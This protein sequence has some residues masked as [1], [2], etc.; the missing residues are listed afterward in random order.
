[1]DDRASPIGVNRDCTPA[2]GLIF[3][4]PRPS[5]YR[6][7]KNPFLPPIASRSFFSLPSFPFFLFHPFSSTRKKDFFEFPFRPNVATRACVTGTHRWKEGRRVKFGVE[8]GASV[9]RS[10]QRAI[11]PC[12]TEPVRNCTN[13]IYTERWKGCSVTRCFDSYP[14]PAVDRCSEEA[15]KTTESVGWF[16]STTARGGGRGAG[17]SIFLFWPGVGTGQN[18]SCNVTSARVNSSSSSTSSEYPSI[19]C[20]R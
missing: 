14:H 19:P 16:Y 11:D 4:P 12:P 10:L 6:H 13:A 7:K 1:M 18:C 9:V 3:H 20:K 8:E 15:K 5:E 17:S 2:P